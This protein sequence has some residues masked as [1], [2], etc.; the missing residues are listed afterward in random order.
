MS[1]R[2]ISM[3]VLLG[4][5]LTAPSCAVFRPSMAAEI[6][7]LAAAEVA[8]TG[9][10]TADPSDDVRQY[11]LAVVADPDTDPDLRAMIADE[12]G[13]R[14]GGSGF[15][16]LALPNGHTWFVSNN[17]VV[18]DSERF[19]VSFDRLTS[20][21]NARVVYADEEFDLA[22]LDIPME[23][24]VASLGPVPKEG[25]PVWAIGSPNG[26]YQVSA[27]TV[28]NRCFKLREHPLLDN[29]FGDRSE[30]YIQHDAAI[31]PGSS[32]GPLFDRATG[33]V[34][35]VNSMG[36]KGRNLA[37]MAIP[38]SSVAT[39]LKRAEASVKNRRNK[40]WMEKSLIEACGRL[41]GEAQSPTVNTS[42]VDWLNSLL[43]G[44]PF[45]WL[46]SPTIIDQNGYG[47]FI[48]WDFEAKMEAA[49]KIGPKIPMRHATVA[50]IVDDIKAEDGFLPRFAVN[51]NDVITK[52]GEVVRVRL[53]LGEDQRE[54]GWRFEQGHWRLI[55]YYSEAIEEA[56]RK[57][58]KERAAEKKAEERAKQ[59]CRAAQK[60]A[61]KEKAEK[62]AADKEKADKAKP[63]SGAKPQPRSVPK[64]DEAK[65]DPPPATDEEETGKIQSDTPPNECAPPPARC[66]S[67]K[68]KGDST[69]AGCAC[70]PRG[71]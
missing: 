60:K 33:K 18:V 66:E 52:P 5:V 36:L 22:V 46:V 21:I 32:G 7:P 27:G 49:A 11:L 57:A 3:L 14:S 62:E 28:T 59:Q 55:G 26:S 10:V 39:V 12:I 9:Q 34:V 13:D 65:T 24:P 30:C 69:G 1:K 50:R 48:A 4:C 29:P 23:R 38:A 67:C 2:A 42:D 41:V 68:L 15:S 71:Q 8:V 25:A 56:D 20:N 19:T 58:A 43:R 54:M 44:G 47:N 17:H 6:K 61:E 45:N 35:G 53:K 16:A 37:F 40:A 51:Q 70:T 31:D 63:K 64:K